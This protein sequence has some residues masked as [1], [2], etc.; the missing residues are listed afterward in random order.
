MPKSSMDATSISAGSAKGLVKGIALVDIVAASAKPLRQVDLVEASGLP[1]PTAVRLLESLVELDVL[2]IE[3]RG[4]YELGPRVA[5]WGQAF[6]DGLDLT[7]Q[8]FDIIEGLVDKSDE[9]SYLGVLDRSSVLYISAVNSPQPVRPAARI[10][11]RNPLHCTGIGK[12]ILAFRTPA[13]RAELLGDGELERR[14]PNTITDR[15]ALAAELDAIAERGYSIDEIENEEG[16]RC[17]AAPVRDHL[18][19]VIAA[20]SVSAP[21]YRFTRE[22]VLEFAPTVVAATSELSARLGYRDRAATA[23]TEASADEPE[24]QLAATK[25]DTDD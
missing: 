15:D 1:R 6:L 23:T 21:A 8:A 14:T 24:A 25:G 17:V 22:D 18:G 7:R 5:A 4:L 9:T 12:A 10:G 16:V 3:S 11:A 13:E 20:I 2:R 19:N